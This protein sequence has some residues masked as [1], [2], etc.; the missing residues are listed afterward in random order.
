MF[1][2]NKYDKNTLPQVWDELRRK[3]NDAQ[4]SLPPGA[5]P[6]IVV[7]DFGD[8]FGVF[9]AITGDE[10]SY[11]ELK[12]YVKML[13]RELLLVQDVAKIDTAKQVFSRKIGNSGKSSGVI[14]RALFGV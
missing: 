12:E 7:D 8:V 4:G 10:Y 1:N 6:S 9:L 3:I 13:Q 11:A 14:L 2:K 5:G